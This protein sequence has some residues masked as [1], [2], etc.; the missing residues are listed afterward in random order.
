MADNDK[1]DT[2]EWAY[3]P[4]THDRGDFLAVGISLSYLKHLENQIAD[5]DANY[6]CSQHFAIKL[7]ACEA[8]R[9]TLKKQLE[10]AVIYI[11]EVECDCQKVQCSRCDTL[12]EIN[13]IEGATDEQ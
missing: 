7:T 2:P 10:R 11:K 6:E 12:A 8:E 5:S 9:D 1:V 13:R 4:I 3:W